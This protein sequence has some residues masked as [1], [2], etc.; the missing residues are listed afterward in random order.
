MV[1]VYIFVKE[2]KDHCDNQHK[3]NIGIIFLMKTWLQVSAK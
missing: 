1:N 2:K 3:G